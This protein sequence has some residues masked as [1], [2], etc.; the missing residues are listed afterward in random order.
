MTSPVAHAAVPSVRTKPGTSAAARS[1][2]TSLQGLIL[3]LFLAYIIGDIF[4]VFQSGNAQPS[5]FVMFLVVGSVVTGLAFKIRESHTL[6]VLL[7][8]LLF[9]IWQVNLFHYWFDYNASHDTGWWSSAHFLW[10]NAYYLFNIGIFL[11]VSTLF[12]HFNTTFI[13][14]VRVTFLLALMIEVVAVIVVSSHAA[15]DQPGLYRSVG[16]YEDPNQLAYW[17]ILALC[18]LLVLAPQQRLGGVE[19]AGIVATIFIVLSS[20]SRSGALGLT[21]VLLVALTTLRIRAALALLACAAVLAIILSWSNT[22]VI[23]AFFEQGTP[24]QIASRFDES[25]DDDNLAGRGYERLWRFP[26]HLFLGAGEGAYWRFRGGT[27]SET[28]F[29]STLGNMLFSYGMVGLGLFGCFL[30][31]VFR[32]APL[33]HAAYFLGPIAWGL[34]NYGGRFSTFWVFL[35]IV[36]ASSIVRARSTG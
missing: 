1:P 13:R 34:F 36:Y 9:W 10:S 6:L 31:E 20:L 11:A 29:H 2:W 32:R 14:S 35:A 21:I 24:A 30:W 15:S 28:E 5:D 18:S 22:R 23:G 27:T 26:E 16:T 17:A 7:A 4:Q 25:D 3:V 19:I 33:R 12:R 8:L